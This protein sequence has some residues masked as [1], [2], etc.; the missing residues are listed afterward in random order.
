MAAIMDNGDGD[1]WI[2]LARCQ[3]AWIAW[4][5]YVAW[6]APSWIATDVQ[7]TEVLGTTSSLAPVQ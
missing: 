3:I 4:I 6:I 5:L 2:A 1:S 7:T